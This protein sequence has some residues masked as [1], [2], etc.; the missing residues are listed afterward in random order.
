MEKDTKPLTN[1]QKQ[2]ILLEKYYRD[3]FETPV[4]GKVN[5]DRNEEIM[6]MQGASQKDYYSQLLAKKVKSLSGV[7][8][9]LS[10]KKR[11]LKIVAYC[12]TNYYDLNNPQKGRIGGKYAESLKKDLI[13]NDPTIKTIAIFGGD[14]LGTEWTMAHLKNATINEDGVA[15]Y[16]GLNKR[17]KRLINDIKIALSTGADVYLMKGAQ[18]HKIFKATGRDILQEVVDEFN[19]PNVTYINEG[20]TVVCNLITS[21]GKKTYNTIAFQTNMIGNAQNA[22]GD[23]RAGIRNN[24]EINADA[25]FVFNGNTAGKFGTNLYHVS[26]QSLF[27]RTAKGKRPQLSP[28]GYNVFMIYPENTHELTIVE[29]NTETMF[30]ENFELEKKVYEQKQTK[31]ALLVLAKEKYEQKLQEYIDEELG[32]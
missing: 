19:L 14:L 17:K 1:A 27:K 20:T 12:S 28:K 10:G 26:G 2:E 13:T 31:K 15:L 29:G 4:I 6:K 21:Y 25:V 5:L 32:E 11:V 3:N 9:V 8:F 7:N 22:N 23:Y 18:E 16:W 30:D 24:G